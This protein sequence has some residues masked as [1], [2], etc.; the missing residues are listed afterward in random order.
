MPIPEFQ[1]IMLPLLKYAADQKEHTMRD[2]GPYI[3]SYFKLSETEKQQRT[4][5]GLQRTIYNRVHWAKT[6][7]VRAVLLETTHRGAYKITQHGISVVEENPREIDI[8][9]L[10]RFPEFVEFRRRRRNVKTEEKAEQKKVEEIQD[11]QEMFEEGYQQIKENLSQE[12][13]TSVINA[14]SEFL[15]KLAVD[16]L[17]RM[18]YGSGQRIGQTGDGG[19]DGIIKEDA[20]G[21]DMIYIQAKCWERGRVMGEPEIARFVG[22]LVA[23]RAQKGVF[24]TTSTFSNPAIAYINNIQ[25]QQ[26]IILI[27]GEKLSQLMIDYDIGVSK[28]AEYNLKRI[29]SDYFIEG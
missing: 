16:L 19:I 26:K 20:L 27:D 8:A 25:H 18:G 21:L 7:M 10:M 23:N 2:A 5:S 1:S 14:G 24:I 13:L 4:P 9:F 22:A 15:E 3:A 6:Y 17:Q 29:D 11:P 12:I 28:M